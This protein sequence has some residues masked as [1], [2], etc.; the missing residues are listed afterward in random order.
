MWSCI[1]ANESNK[2]GDPLILALAANPP[3]FGNDL[4]SLSK[5]TR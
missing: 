2:G 3:I 4:I 1:Y 5:Y